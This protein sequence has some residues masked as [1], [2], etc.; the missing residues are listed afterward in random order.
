MNCANKNYNVQN[1][2]INRLMTTIITEVDKTRRKNHSEPN[3]RNARMNEKCNT[4]PKENN[5]NVT[6]KSRKI[7]NHANKNDNVQNDTINTDTSIVEVDKTENMN[8]SEPMFNK[9][10][11]N[12]KFNKSR[13]DNNTRRSKRL[14]ENGNK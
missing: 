1:N 9:R 6:R 7:M 11:M 8:N 10:P 2:M 4:S 5:C 14:M 12:E 3:H 13:K